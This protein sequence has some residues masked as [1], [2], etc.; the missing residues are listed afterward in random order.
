MPNEMTVTTDGE[1]VESGNAIQ[2]PEKVDPT[3]QLMQSAYANASALRLTPE[4]SKALLAEFPDEAFRKGAGGDDKLLYMEHAYLRDRLNE[5]LGLGQWSMIVI[6]HW[7]NDQGD[8]TIVYV[9]GMLVIRGCYVYKA[10]GD[11]TYIH[12]NKKTN[13]G[14]AVEGATGASLRRCCKWF[15]VGLQAWKKAWC[16][17]WWKRNPSGVAGQ[18]PGQNHQTQENRKPTTTPSQSSKPDDKYGTWSQ[19]ELSWLKIAREGGWEGLDKAYTAAGQK[20]KDRLQE[21]ILPELEKV[22][23]EADRIKKRVSHA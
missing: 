5:V 22:A 3:L 7:A 19:V 12:T 9:E 2:R 11:M 4:E 6:Q 1:I 15:G 14:D 16:E 8:R 21:T 17:G 18:H 10:V 23:R 20:T 13:H